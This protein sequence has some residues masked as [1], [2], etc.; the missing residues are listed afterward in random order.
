[1][2]LHGPGDGRRDGLAYA[3]GRVGWSLPRPARSELLA[4]P[5]AAGARFWPVCLGRVRLR[6]VWGWGLPGYLL[7]WDQKGYWATNVATNLATLV[8]VV[9]KDI[10]QLA[11][12]GNAYGHHTLTRFFD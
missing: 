11:V 7:P 6:L 4:G 12:G 10:Q 5:G 1:P 3:A 8:P 9:G 2:P